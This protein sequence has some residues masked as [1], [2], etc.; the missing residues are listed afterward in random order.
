MAFVHTTG[1]TGRSQGAHKE[2]GKS[3]KLREARKRRHRAKEGTSG[4]SCT[5]LAHETHG[6]LGDEAKEQTRML[7]DDIYSHSSVN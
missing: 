5:A 7:A 2:A 6:R 1:R 3:V 4:Y